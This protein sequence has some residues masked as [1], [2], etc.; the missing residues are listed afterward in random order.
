MRRLTIQ[1]N[2]LL[3]TVVGSML[4]VCLFGSSLFAQGTLQRQVK[5][6][7]ANGNI[8]T[9]Q[10]DTPTT[11]FTISLPNN[12]NPSFG[13]A[14]LLFGIGNGQMV[15]SS[16]LGADSGHV[17]QLNRVGSKLVPS[18]R[19]MA[20]L[21]YVTNDE[22][23]LTFSNDRGSLTDNRVFSVGSGLSITNS[24]VD[25]GNLIVANTGVLKL[26]A[27]TGVTLSD[28]TG[29]IIISTRGWQLGGNTGTSPWNG[30]VGDFL[31]TTDD[32]DLVLGA[33]SSDATRER[34]RISNAT[35]NIRL[36]TSGAQLQLQGTGNGI[37]SFQAG[38]QGNTDINYTL[39]TA[40]PSQNGQ[41]LAAS[42]AGVLSWTTPSGGLTGSGTA[43]RIA[44][45]GP[46]PGT[47]TN[48][49]DDTTLYYD[50]TNKR[51]SLGA[52]VSPS[53]TLHAVTSGVKTTPT[54]GTTFS[55]TSTSTTASITKVGL[56]VQSTGTWTGSGAT[57]IGV[58]VHASGGTT[59]YSALFGGGNV[60][61]GT[62]TP[63]QLLT[64]Q[65]GNLLLSNNDGNAGI[66]VLQGTGTGAST[67]SSGAQGTTTIN[68]VLPTSLPTA[69]QQL[70]ASAI[71]GTG[72]YN[73][74]MSWA[75]A[76]S[77]G[78][79][80]GWSLTGNAGTTAG[81][82][83]VGTTD[84][85]DLVIK[86]NNS[87]RL[88]VLGTGEIGVG[89]TTP[90]TQLDLTG[91]LATREYNYTTA[92]P[93][94]LNNANFDG[95]GNQVGFVRLSSA[96]APFSIT[97]I[98]GGVNGKMMS[99]YNATGQSMT[100]V[101]QSTSST[102]ANR[103][104]TG[105]SANIPLPAG[106]T[107]NFLYSAQDS[108][109]VVRSISGTAGWLYTG[110]SGLVDGTSNFHGT[111]D[112]IPIRFVAGNNGPKQ[113][114][115]LD[116]RGNLLFGANSAN[117]TFATGSAGKLAFGDSLNTLRL[118]SLPTFGARVFSMIDP[119]AVVRVWRFRSNA[120]G[121]DPA[122]ELI[123]GTDDIELDDNN[124]KWDFYS[125]GTPGVPWSGTKSQGE[126]FAVRRRTQ[127]N[128][129][130]YLAV[131]AGSG[132]RIGSDTTGTARYTP[133]KL[134][135]LS[136]DQNTNGI[137]NMAALE[138]L[139]MGN[140]AAGL[141]SGLLFR[142]ET[143]LNDTVRD[144][145]R[146]AGIWTNVS[147]GSRSGAL[148]F[149]TVD[150]ASAMTERARIAS[151]G[152]M[153]LNTTAPNVRLDI[154]GAYATRALNLQLSSGRNDDIDI[155]DASF[156]RITGP[157]ADFSISGIDD[158]TDG[159]RVRIVNTTGE[160]M[161][162]LN[163]STNS[164][165]DNRITT[166]TN[167]DVIVKGTDAVLE[168]TYDATGTGKWLFGTLSANQVIGPVGSIVYKSKTADETVTSSATIQDD[169]HLFFDVNE[170]QTWE[171][172]GQL[173]VDNSSNNVNVK[174]AFQLPTGA[175]MKMYVTGIQDAGGN[176]IQGSGL[177]TT[178]NASKTILISGGVSTLITFRGVITTGSSSGTVE[179]RWA[180]GTS[181]NSGTV[182]RSGSYM[183]IMRVE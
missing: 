111:L 8:I 33:G 181:N 143:S 70:T 31:G 21:N 138:H 41:V 180:Q 43:T 86:T 130:V 77:S 32:K 67:I 105:T 72:P 104:I 25:N 109:W 176:A 61:I 160:E 74:A 26:T 182:I 18:W 145:A 125:T 110:N 147:D 126:H 155:G 100:I 171:L 167:D 53:S 6:S 121:T 169:N 12:P 3:L 51:L 173:Q 34:L 63:A 57:N 2:A 16:T 85:I 44:F 108:R 148:T 91:D 123:G 46:G 40:L 80:S 164:S 168:M 122:V 28:T 83:F 48:L 11:S 73:I 179:F 60:G 9:L 174:V 22:P 13:T 124:Q 47:T 135:V 112:S 106:G 24:G 96:S 170:N 166:G 89:T 117:T 62:I 178:S 20:N 10:S 107:A 55:N 154:N 87:E 159:K 64:L 90:N 118:N 50:N 58:I 151:N 52:G 59:N 82:N 133:Y 17:L 19:S 66:L 49:M 120:G 81:T 78:G 98:T 45:W 149:S 103:M 5:I 129:S 42:T 88:R 15:W 4:V 1:S 93:T 14:S 27:G 75:P 56:D 113:R 144:M 71:T 150:G 136:E 140:A 92:V 94:T 175:T 23:I 172:N 177:M 37:T 79:S 29:N 137:M 127:G 116:P 30:T 102:A 76:G 152:Y 165:S 142:G 54:T 141:G 39:P 139:A 183:K 153:G 162:I 161:T 99:I 97:G 131:F 114:M 36:T 157:T 69:G 95:A 68:Y 156:V 101:N 163:A 7:N 84:N 65:N 134:A 146:I 119:N 35:G 132:V 38:A 158:G 128:D 115:V